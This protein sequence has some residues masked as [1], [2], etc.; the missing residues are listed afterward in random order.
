MKFP[1]SLSAVLPAC[2]LALSACSSV[3]P[4]DSVATGTAAATPAAAPEVRQLGEIVDLRSGQRLS[5]EQLLAQL[6]AAPRVIIGEQHDQ[7]SHHRIE[8]WLLQQ[9]QGRR[10]QGSVLLEMLNPD[11]QAKVDKVKP[12]LQTDPVVRPEHVAELV[13]WQPNWKWEQY[14]DLVMTVM[15]APYPVWSANLDRSEIKQ[16]FADKPGVQGKHSNLA[17]D[18]KVHDKLKDIIRVMHDN[19]IDEPRLAAMLSVQQQRDRRMAE[20]LLAAPAPA[21]LIAGAYHAHKDL[22]VPL[23]VQDLTGGPAPLVLVL[24]RQGAEVKASQADF[25]WFTPVAAPAVASAR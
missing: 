14:G 5:A 23:H 4:A 16:M 8:Q 17:N 25:V 24:A 21:V 7:L 20:R 6:A 15:R 13:A 12:W 11:Q 22:G 2:V 18:G 10:P 1:L 3:A 9:L 19:Q